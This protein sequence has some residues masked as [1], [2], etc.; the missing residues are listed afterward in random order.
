[1]CSKHS[2]LIQAY[3]YLFIYLGFVSTSAMADL[4]GQASSPQLHLITATPNQC[5][6]LNKGQTCYQDIV[7]KWTSPVAGDYCVRSSQRKEPLQCWKGHSNGEHSLRVETTESVLFTLNE[8]P[9]NRKVAE[10]LMRVAWVYKQSRRK[11]A[12]W[13]LF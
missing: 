13:R 1:M 11:L 3:R 2:N 10:V 4:A 8:S 9:E 7:L 12:S 6:A 5:V